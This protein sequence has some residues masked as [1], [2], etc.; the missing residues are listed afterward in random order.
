MAELADV[1][2]SQGRLN[3]LGRPVSVT[4]MQSEGGAA[5]ALHG[6]ASAGALVT[7]FTASQVSLYQISLTYYY[8]RAC[9]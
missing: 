7:T 6:A 3:V 1:W 2:S 9:C 8:S 5:G 4:Q